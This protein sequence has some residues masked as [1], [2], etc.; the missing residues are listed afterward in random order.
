MPFFKTM[1]FWSIATAYAETIALIHVGNSFQTL[2]YALRENGFFNETT[3]AANETAPTTPEQQSQI[4]S[5]LFMTNLTTCLLMSLFIGFVTDAKG[6]WWSRCIGQIFMVIGIVCGMMI[7]LER[8][9][10]VFVAYPL[11]YAGG[12]VNSEMNMLCYILYPKKMG[13]LSSLTGFS[14]GAAQAWYIW[15]KDLCLPFEN[16]KYFWMVMLALMPLMTVRTF[17]LMPKLKVTIDIDRLG[18]ETRND[19]YATFGKKAVDS[20]EEK[21][22]MAKDEAEATSMITP[23]EKD[24]TL[25]S[26]LF[27]PPVLALFCWCLLSDYRVFL[28]YSKFQPW[29]R[30]KVGGLNATESEY[31]SDVAIGNEIEIKATRDSIISLQTSTF[32]WCMMSQ[33][34][35][36]PFCGFFI[37]L[38][39]KLYRSKLN[40]DHKKSTVLTCAVGLAFCTIFLA[41]ISFLQVQDFNGR[42]I[43]AAGVCAAFIDSIRFSC[44]FMF[45]FTIIDSRVVGRVMGFGSFL[46]IM[47]NGL[48]SLTNMFVETYCGGNWD[49]V[50]GPLGYI[51]VF[52]LLFPAFIIYYYFYRGE[53]NEE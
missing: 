41:G 45:I 53:A 30:Y 46:I 6:T 37:D 44:K 19:D 52:S 40:L 35:T 4:Y 38:A 49:Q 10:L 36:D 39:S 24:P 3:N 28:Y 17:L 2:E 34:L 8:Q 29:L 27:R 33:M 14:V 42:F 1:K 11:F 50:F 48:I 15:Y 51:T 31:F 43:V 32:T 25:F 22:M 20:E 12:M 13:M 9:Y 5:N 16:L 21:T 26:E 18:W 23:A 7:S 47:V